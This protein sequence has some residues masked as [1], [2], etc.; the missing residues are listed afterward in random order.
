MENRAFTEGFMEKMSEGIAPTNFDPSSLVEGMMKSE[1]KPIAPKSQAAPSL[2]G[3]QSANTSIKS[4]LPTPPKQSGTYDE[5]LA[6]EANARRNAP[7]PTYNTSPEMQKYM[8]LMSD[9]EV[10]DFKRRNE[11][12]AAEWAEKEM[13]RRES[14]Y[15]KVLRGATRTIPRAARFAAKKIAP[16]AVPY[17]GQAA[18]ALEAASLAAETVPR[19]YRAAKKKIFPPDRYPRYYNPPRKQ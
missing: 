11:A 2:A 16:K 12:Q 1:R 19:V 3:Q 18:T 13:R 6:R 10:G 15:E 14:K 5:H 9:K 7:P 17:L 4:T 8:D